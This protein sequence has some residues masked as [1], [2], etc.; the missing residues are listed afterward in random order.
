MI[1]NKE[2]VIAD[3]ATKIAMSSIQLFQEREGVK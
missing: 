3:S 2:Q 1:L